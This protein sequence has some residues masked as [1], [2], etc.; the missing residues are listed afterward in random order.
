MRQSGRMVVRLRSIHQTATVQRPL[1]MLEISWL[2]VPMLF[3]RLLVAFT[4]FAG[5][6]VS[7][8]TAAQDRAAGKSATGAAAPA[9]KSAAIA[10]VP[11]V[12][13]ETPLGTIILRV[14]PE[15]APL[16]AANFLKYVDMKRY[17]GQS[18][19]RTTRNWGAPSTLIQ[20][21]IRSDAR[22]LLPPVAHEPTNMTGLTHCPGSVSLAR[23]APGSGR[24]DFFLAL[25]PIY[26]FDAD[27][28]ASGDNAGFAV[29]AE[30]VGGWQV[31]EA[32][33]AASTSPTAGDGV[34]KGQM[35]A[36][37]VKITRA[38]RVPVPAAVDPLKPKPGCTVKGATGVPAA[39]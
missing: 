36:P 9:P 34:M 33:A 28:K 14:H 3:A 24:S 20:A 17:D 4:A 12:A 29:F 18:F 25:G 32:I 5:L 8:V 13:F 10:G 21:G 2:L 15:Q 22:L 19:Y 31:A 23:G 35:L 7:P 27:P 16:T 11:H 37:P 1:A 26:G 30:V 39:P 6:I 38:Y